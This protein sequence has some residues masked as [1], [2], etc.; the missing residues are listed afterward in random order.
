MCCQMVGDL[1]V[2]ICGLERDILAQHAT[3]RNADFG[4]NSEIIC[5]L[6]ISREGS[7]LMRLTIV[8]IIIMRIIIITIIISFFFKV[9]Y[10]QPREDN[11]KTFNADDV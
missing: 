1:Q 5:L 4:D 2:K 8:E 10:L 6:V 7:G 11:L 3:C 9:G